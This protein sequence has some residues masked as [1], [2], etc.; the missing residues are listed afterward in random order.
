MLHLSFVF[1][2]Q[3]SREST[4]AETIC[5]CQNPGTALTV[6]TTFYVPPNK[7]DFKAVFV[8]T[9]PLG[10]TPV[11]GTIIA[12]ISGFVLFVFWAWRADLK[13]KYKVSRDRDQ[14]LLFQYNS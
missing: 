5:E 3:V 12:V 4:R 8:D 10:N 11:L 6:G 1:L 13:D 9:D 7:I 2:Y 14:L